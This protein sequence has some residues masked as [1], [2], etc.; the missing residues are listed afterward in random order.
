[1][2]IAVQ[3]TN[4]FEDYNVFLRSM[5]VAMSGKQDSDKEILV[6]SLGPKTING[7]VTGFCNLTERSLK[8]RGIKIKHRRV[9]ISW[10][11]NE[12]EG[13]DYFIFLSKPSEYASKLSAQAEL[14]GVEV[15]V[16]RY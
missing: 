9:P 7:F 13:L 6:Y 1:M 14:K 3:G 10:M 16:F 2:I 5:S 8:S 12:L 11:E 15:G 4:S